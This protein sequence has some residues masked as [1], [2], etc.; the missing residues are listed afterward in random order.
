VG[1]GV[2]PRVWG[3]KLPVCPHRRRLDGLEAGGLEKGDL[4]ADP[5]LDD[6]YN[7]SI[8]ITHFNAY[9]V[10]TTSVVILKQ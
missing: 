4:D 3:P 6:F 9:F 10:Q 5:P 7:F 8:K 2:W 1:G